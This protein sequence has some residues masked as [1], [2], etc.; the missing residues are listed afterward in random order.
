MSQMAGDCLGGGGGGMGGFGID[1]YIS[2]SSFKMLKQLSLY[3]KQFPLVGCSQ[4]SLLFMPSSE[5]QKFTLQ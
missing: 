3:T 2:T 1:W 5:R 4:I